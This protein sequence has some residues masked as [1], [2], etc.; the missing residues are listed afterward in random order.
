MIEIR[1]Q[2]SRMSL[3]QF[4]DENIMGVSHMVQQNITVLEFLRANLTG[5]RGILPA[6]ESQMPS[7]TFFSLV[8]FLAFRATISD[9]LV[10]ETFEFRILFEG[11]CV[12]FDAYKKQYLASD[13]ITPNLT[14]S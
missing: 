5:K 9:V 10:Y 4:F 1:F 3:S 11:R 6:I 2:N 7:E 12:K 8:G 13:S 14:K